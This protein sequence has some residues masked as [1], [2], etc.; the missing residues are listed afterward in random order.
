VINTNS[1]RMK[2]QQTVIALALFGAGFHLHAQDWLDAKDLTNPVNDG[3]YV[4]YRASPLPKLCAFEKPLT[5]APADPPSSGGGGAG[6]DDKA[7]AAEL[8]KKLQN[9][10]ASLVSVPIQQNWDFGYGSANAMRYTVNV[11]PVIPVTL[12][13][14]WNLITRTIVPIIYA[15][16][17]SATDRDKFGLGDVLQSFFFSPKEPVSG[18]IVGAGPALLWPTATDPLLGAGRYAA[19]PTVVALQ[20]T[21]GWTYGALANHLWSYAG[22]GNREVN[23]TFL[24]PFVSYTT[25]SFTTFGLNTES[26][27]DWQ[28]GQWSVPVNLSVSQLVKVG[29]QPISLSL[30]G[31]YY[32]EGP[33]GGP[34]WGLRVAVTF[35]FP[36]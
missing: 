30:G 25:K 5:L 7:A 1:N 18:W 32:A 31:R 22:W 21:K 17:T 35:L 28:A 24:Q 4:A 13:K 6:A 16:K 27:Y 15:E 23:A 14:D 9:P 3:P 34:D 20:Q 8:A 2:K 11:Q 29:K 36:K 26:S 10:I 12:N 19:G 33:Q